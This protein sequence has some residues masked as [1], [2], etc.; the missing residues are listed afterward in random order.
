MFPTC[1]WSGEECEDEE[2]S[3]QLPDLKTLGTSQYSR[4]V[5]PVVIQVETLFM[6]KQV[7]LKLT[8]ISLILRAFLQLTKKPELIS[9]AVSKDVLLIMNAL[10]GVPGLILIKS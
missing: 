4:T 8:K 10:M 2:T 7:I 1:Q 9:I 5:V 6:I 3:L